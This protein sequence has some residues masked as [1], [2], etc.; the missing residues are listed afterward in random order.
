MDVDTLEAQAPKSAPSPEPPSGNDPSEPPN[1]KGNQPPKKTTVRKRT[2]T[3]CLTCRRRRIK[4]DEGKPTCGNC[5]KSKRQCEGYNQRIVFKESMGP[6]PSGHLWGHPVYHQQ[7]QEALLNAQLSEAQ[8]KAASSQGPLAAIAPKPLSVDFSGTGTHPYSQGFAGPSNHSIAGPPLFSPQHIDPQQ[9]HLPSPQHLEPQHHLPSPPLLTPNTVQYPDQ[10]PS[11]GDGLPFSDYYGAQTQQPVSAL[12]HVSPI[13]GHHG[14][15]SHPQPHPHDQGYG[16]GHG[17]EIR[18]SVETPQLASPDTAAAL[19]GTV[20]VEEGYWQ[21]DDEASMMASDDEQGPIDPHSSHL[22][23]NDLG[24]LVARRLDTDGDAYGV[25]IRSFAGHN[26]TNVLDTYMP[27]SANS[28]LNDSQTAAIFW[29]FVN[30][31]GQSMSLYERHPFDPTP[32]FQGQPVAKERQ[33]IWTYTFPIMAFNHPALMQ[34]MLAL[35]SLQ[36]AKLQG[37]PPTAAMKHYHLSLRRIAKNYQSP[38]RRIQPATLAATLLL[39]FYEVWNSDHDKW[40]KHMWGARAILKELPLRQMT[41]DILTLKRRQREQARR[42]HQCDE[43]CFDSRHHEQKDDW[44]EPDTEFIESLTGLKRD[45]EKYE[46][47]RDLY[48]WYC[49]MDIY[50]SFLGGT[51]PFMNYEAWTQCIPR[52]PFGKIDS[53][54]GTFDHLMLLLGRLASFASKDLTRKRKARK[55]GPPPGAP[56]GPGGPPGS[57]PPGGPPGGFEGGP[58]GRFPGG[59][60]PG[61]GPPGGFPGGPPGTFPGAP[62]GPGQGRG[63]SPPPFTGLMPSSGTFDIP[64]GFSPPREST[65]PPDS[66]SSSEEP[67]DFS[68]STAKAL[69][70]WESIRAAF[71]LFRSKLGPDFEPMGPDFAPPDMTPFGP[72]LIY[73]TYSIAGIW[74]NYYMGLIILHRSHPSMPPIAIYAAGMAAQQTGRWANE[75]ARIAAGLHEDTTHVSAVSTLVGAAFIESCFCLFV[76]GVQFQSLPQRHFTIRRLRDIARLTGW[77]S[78]RQI[79]DGCESGW[80]KA[81]SLG[82]GPPYHSPPELGPLFPD[83]IWNRPRR[84]DRRIREIE[85]SEEAPDGKLVLAK[86]EQAHY[87]L[88]LLSVER[89]LDELVIVEEED[90]KRRK[91]GN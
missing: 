85:A 35:G 69:Q 8:T 37:H 43:F 18:Q 87:A 42:N 27:S 1:G 11:P 14:Q 61:A 83:N 26:A 13:H 53:I 84:I 66:S 51:R 67:E 74:M 28:P 89:D 6:F 50:Q 38:T 86:T 34:A 55:Y 65:P 22:E 49:K 10:Y 57:G 3:G 30:V 41:R 90:E 76:A 23:S 47:I 15:Y 25:H 29:Y 72:A 71:E 63:A 7:A 56:G 58:P 4:C 21:S 9:H 81:A 52:G 33:H 60:P 5:I 79:A 44:P 48:W 17:Q 36:M 12:G 31:T 73:R 19:S 32:M 75:I 91:G 24:I 82:R 20:S 68:T 62:P 88:G 78:A 16:H 46:Q 2:K 77:Q 64:K 39:G 59:G 45:V 54:Y 70:E 80:N 40:C